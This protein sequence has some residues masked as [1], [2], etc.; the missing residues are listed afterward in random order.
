M[1]SLSEVCLCDLMNES[2]FT[3]I[4]LGDSAISIY[5]SK[6]NGNFSLYFSMKPKDESIR[7]DVVV[8]IFQPQILGIQ[9]MS[10]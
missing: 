7:D 1:A 5:H 9:L 8:S 10:R 2:N 3:N 6:N 4:I